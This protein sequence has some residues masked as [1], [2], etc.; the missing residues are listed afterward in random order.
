MDVVGIVATVATFLKASCALVNQ[1]YRR[2]QKFKCNAARKERL[3][4]LTEVLADIA[5]K[6]PDE[7]DQTE[8]RVSRPAIAYFF[9][10][11]KECDRYCD[12]IEKKCLASK[13]ACMDKHAQEFKDIENEL[14]HA[15]I[16]LIFAVTSSSLA[17]NLCVARALQKGSELVDGSAHSTSVVKFYPAQ[18]I[19]V[20]IP[21]A[22][23]EKPTVDLEGKN[24]V[25]RWTDRHNSPESLLC[26]EVLYVD[27]RQLTTHQVEPGIRRLLL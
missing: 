16:I 23:V 21:P 7:P 26:Y 4:E 11:I 27:E 10:R 8:L 2:V 22:R 1:V 17:T 9:E 5:N 12:A 14:N 19:N 13:V 3:Q 24:F 25:V 20:L 6:L 18:G 15:L